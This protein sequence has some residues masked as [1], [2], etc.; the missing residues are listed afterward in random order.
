MREWQ[1]LI[2][3][4]LPSIGDGLDSLEVE[5][6]IVSEEK[7]LP[8]LAEDGIGVG[9][10]MDDLRVGLLLDVLEKLRAGELLL[11]RVGLLELAVGDSG[12][13]GPDIV[14]IWI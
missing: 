2:I 12:V 5:E 6:P 1:F 3:W 14:F 11:V 7:S 9:Y 13:H 8:F 10:S 4:E